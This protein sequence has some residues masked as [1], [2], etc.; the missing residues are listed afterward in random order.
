M[1]YRLTQHAT[2]ALKKRRIPNEWVERAL[3][4]PEWIE[5]DDI[6]PELEHR[7]VRI[8]EFGGRVLRVI[9]NP[10]VDPFRIITVYF[11]RGR[12]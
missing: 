2:D 1:K 10:A 7:L 3:F 5:P 12:K 9:V 6:D 11:D 8:P 4:Q